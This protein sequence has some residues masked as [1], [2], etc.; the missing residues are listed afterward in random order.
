[1]QIGTW[2]CQSGNIRITDPCY[3]RNSSYN[4]LIDN[5]ITGIWN[6]KITYELYDFFFTNDKYTEKISSLLTW[7][8]DY[9]V[10]SSKDWQ[11]YSYGIITNTAQVGVFDDMYYPINDT[12]TYYKNTFYRKCCNNATSKNKFGLVAY[13]NKY[14][15]VNTAIEF[16]NGI[17]PIY[18]H[19]NKQNKINGIMINFTKPIVENLINI[20]NNTHK[21][22]N[23]KV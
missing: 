21:K 13:N 18:I 9:D 7:H 15:G 11:K 1:M 2:H 16:G 14:F 10:F 22:I 12:G 20:I 4:L 23:K 5:I 8:Y 3:D 17:F 19:K 6:A